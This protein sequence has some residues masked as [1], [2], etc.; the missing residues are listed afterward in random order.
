M[1]VPTDDDS[2][3]RMHKLTSERRF[4][5]SLAVVDAPRTQSCPVSKDDIG[6]HLNEARI[7]SNDTEVGIQSGNSIGT[8]LRSS[9]VV[10]LLAFRSSEL[11]EV[12]TYSFWLC[13]FVIADC[14]LQS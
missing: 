4:H 2:A 7:I 14:Y 11:R 8:R 3:S 12:I 13:A 5:C 9:D 1:S 10:A 6:D